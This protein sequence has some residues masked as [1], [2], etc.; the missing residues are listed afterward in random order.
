MLRIGGMGDK[1]SADGVCV[2]LRVRACIYM[3]VKSV[4]K[5][6]IINYNY[7]QIFIS[8]QYMW[9]HKIAFLIHPIANALTIHDYKIGGSDFNPASNE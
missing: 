1:F 5:N 9:L 2:C 7:F 4:P 3:C 8:K 6:C